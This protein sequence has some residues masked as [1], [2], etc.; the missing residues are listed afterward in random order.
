MSFWCVQVVAARQVLRGT[1]EDLIRE[2]RRREA[3][4]GAG[5]AGTRSKGTSDSAAGAAP[6]HSAKVL[7]PPRRS[8][9]R[10][11]GRQDAAL[12]RVVT[13]AWLAQ[14]AAAARTQARAIK[15]GSFLSLLVNARHTDSGEHLTELEA[16]AQAY[17]FLLAGAPCLELTVIRTVLLAGVH[18]RCAWQGMFTCNAAA[19]QMIWCCCAGV[20]AGKPLH[21]HGAMPCGATAV[22]ACSVYCSQPHCSPLQ[23]LRSLLCTETLMSALPE[24][25]APTECLTGPVTAGYETTATALA[26]TVHCL[27][28]NPDKCERLLQARNHALPSH[29]LHGINTCLG[30]LYG[31][32]IMSMLLR[33]R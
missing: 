19:I 15:P 5:G 29:L 30:A 14:D 32:L 16:A 9:G 10:W 12:E 25:P 2:T 3:A 33:R 22:A 8:A 31:L 18:P 27:A 23:A 26:F 13:A 28:A 7:G 21:S 1:V 4:G 24:T 11:D 6:K 17:T 20:P